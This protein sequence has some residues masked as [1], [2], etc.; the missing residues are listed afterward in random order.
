MNSAQKKLIGSI[1]TVSGV[2]LLAYG[3]Y[4]MYLVFDYNNAMNEADQNLGGLVSGI[5]DLIGSDV[6]D[7][8]AKGGIFAGFGLLDIIIGWVILGNVK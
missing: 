8:Y 6:K 1:L 4:E 5:S 7:S 2:A 3:C